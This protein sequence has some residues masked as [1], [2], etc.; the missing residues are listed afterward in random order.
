MDKFKEGRLKA[1]KTCSW[2]DTRR[3]LES[4]NRLGKIE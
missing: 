1:I 2:A 3:Y 4:G